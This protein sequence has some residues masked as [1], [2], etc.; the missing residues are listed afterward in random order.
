MIV[1]R[2]INLLKS[3]VR[4][5]VNIQ[6]AAKLDTIIRSELSWLLKRNVPDSIIHHQSAQH[7]ASLQGIDSFIDKGINR[8]VY[9]I[10]YR[11][12]LL[13]EEINKV[14]TW[15]GIFIIASGILLIYT[16][17]NLFRQKTKP[18]LK[19]KNCRLFLTGSAM[20]WYLLIITGSI[21]F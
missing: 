17:I 11:K 6:I 8:T 12:K 21:P 13:H 2:Q 14:R 15:M 5:T 20:G 7:I 3:T 19:K 16:T 4:D 18:K 1:I 9:L 10:E